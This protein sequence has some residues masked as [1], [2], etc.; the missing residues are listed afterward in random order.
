MNDDLVQKLIHAIDNVCI[1]RTSY[2]IEEMNRVRMEVVEEMNK[3][4]KD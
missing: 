3:R 4:E 1:Y 2:M